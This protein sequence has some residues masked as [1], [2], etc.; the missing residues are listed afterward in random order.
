MS[1]PA[2][3]AVERSLPYEY[4]ADEV[5]ADVAVRV[6]REVLKPIRELHQPGYGYKLPRTESSRP[7]SFCKHCEV[8][9]PCDT[10]KL[11]YTTEELER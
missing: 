6:A 11:I 4:E 7:E 3:E 1:D 8:K 9:W 2:I 10:A 5:M